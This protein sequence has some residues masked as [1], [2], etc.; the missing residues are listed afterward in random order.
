MPARHHGGLAY[1][2]RYGRVCASA[3]S[4]GRESDPELRLRGTAGLECV[5]ALVLQAGAGKYRS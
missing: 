3:S 4:S 5:T 2:E 1:A